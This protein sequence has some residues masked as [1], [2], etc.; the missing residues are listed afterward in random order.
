LIAGD[1]VNDDTVGGHY[2]DDWGAENLGSDKNESVCLGRAKAI[3]EYCD[4]TPQQP[5][6]ATFLDTGNSA[7]YPE[8]NMSHY[9]VEIN[10]V[11]KKL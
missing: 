6:K 3:W 2:L 1:C 5:V 9:T 4:N 8:G 7:T 11:G 10:M